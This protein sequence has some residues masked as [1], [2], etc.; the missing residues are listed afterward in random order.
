MENPENECE[1]CM[2]RLKQVQIIPCNHSVCKECSVSIRPSRKCPFCRDEF[3]DFLDIESSLII[4]P[5]PIVEPRLPLEIRLSDQFRISISDS[6]IFT[7][8]SNIR[9]QFTMREPIPIVVPVISPSPLIELDHR[10]NIDEHTRHVEIA[11]HMSNVLPR[12][13]L[14]NVYDN[15]GNNENVQVSDLVEHLVTRSV[16]NYRINSAGYSHFF[17]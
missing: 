17:R 15:H 10:S 8:G 3:Q 14:V 5:P 2:E 13:N 9:H 11:I 16:P 7:I 1:I 6:S 4:E 12:R